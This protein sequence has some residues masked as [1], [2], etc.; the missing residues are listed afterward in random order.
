[1]HDQIEDV[2]HKIELKNA[3]KRKLNDEYFVVIR[4]K[5]ICISMMSDLVFYF[6]DKKNEFLEWPVAFAFEGSKDDHEQG[7]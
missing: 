6:R 4:R 1:M 7:S 2:S 5:T 3:V